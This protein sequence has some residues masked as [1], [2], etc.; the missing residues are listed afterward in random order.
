MKFEKLQLPATKWILSS[1]NGYKERLTKI[2]L[3]LLSLYV[4]MHDLLVYLTIL[5]SKYDIPVSFENYHDDKTRQYSM[6]EHLISQN[7]LSKSDHN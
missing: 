6:G 1:L 7:R 3:L 5:K 4:E 2:N